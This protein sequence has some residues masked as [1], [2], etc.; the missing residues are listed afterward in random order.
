MT[1]FCLFSRVAEACVKHASFSSHEKN[2][3]FLL[4]V[5]PH[6]FYHGLVYRFFVTIDIQENMRTF[7]RQAGPWLGSIF[8]YM[9]VVVEIW[10]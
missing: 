10:N 5:L 9:A 4:Q 1:V 3:L 6:Y 8:L 7:M 2:F